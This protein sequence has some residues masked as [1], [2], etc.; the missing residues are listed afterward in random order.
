MQHKVR[1]RQRRIQE[2]D[3]SRPS[4]A[5]Y[6]ST[7]SLHEPS[8]QPAGGRK[9]KRRLSQSQ[10]SEQ[11]RSAYRHDDATSEE[12]AAY[13]LGAGPRSPRTHS[14]KAP[15]H[16]QFYHNLRPERA[17]TSNL[18]AAAEQGHRRVLAAENLDRQG[19]K[20]RKRL[21]LTQS[22]SQPDFGD[23]RGKSD[24]QVLTPQNQELKGKLLYGKADRKGRNGMDE[25]YVSEK[26]LRSSH[27]RSKALENRYQMYN[28]MRSLKRQLTL[29]M[30]TLKAMKKMSKGVSKYARN[31]SSRSTSQ[32]AMLTRDTP[33]SKN[34]SQQ[35]RKSRSKS[36]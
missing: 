18:K 5:G 7:R 10:H 11:P 29:G 25:S 22:N 9:R 26:S 19:D 3:G 17:R 4:N 30:N 1:E 35:R 36:A 33:K 32:S 2:R 20:E 28:D 23:F 27:S 31:H 21:K 24:R 14:A 8:S 13:G 6:R 34:G 12:P 16:Y 15:S